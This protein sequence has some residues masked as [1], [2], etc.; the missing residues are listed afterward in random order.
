M[1]TRTHSTSSRLSRCVMRNLC[2]VKGW[3]IQ[4]NI[5]LLSNNLFSVFYRMQYYRIEDNL[6]VYLINVNTYFIITTIGYNFEIDKD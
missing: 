5:H 6:N 2:N 3:I 1:H 4:F